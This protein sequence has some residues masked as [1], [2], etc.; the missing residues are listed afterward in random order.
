MAT[1][2]NQPAPEED[3]QPEYNFR[4]MRG[5]VRGKYA[6]RYRER[7]RMVRLEEDVSAAF[8]DEAAVNAALREYIT[9]RQERQT[10]TAAQSTA[11]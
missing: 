6:A 1:S 2:P 7:L 4:S 8:A 10:A 9:W 3:L 11:G 5:V